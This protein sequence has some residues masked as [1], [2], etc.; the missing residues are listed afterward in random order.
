MVVPK[1]RKTEQKRSED[2]IGMIIFPRL[3][4]AHASVEVYRVLRSSWYIAKLFRKNLSKT[5]TQIC[6]ESREV[7]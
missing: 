6:R 5:I 3:H 4:G 7:K 2:S 1:V